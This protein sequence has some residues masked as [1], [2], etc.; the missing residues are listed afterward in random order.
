MDN[1]Q[2]Q[3][4]QYEDIARI[5]VPQIAILVQESGFIP[6]LEVLLTD[7]N[8]HMVCCLQM[9]A[10]GEFRSLHDRERPLHARFPVNVTVT[11]KNGESWSTSLVAE[12]LPSLLD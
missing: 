12:D 11:D 1:E 10:T 8:S 4:E 2:V 9:S 7:T 3:S 5:L 6:P